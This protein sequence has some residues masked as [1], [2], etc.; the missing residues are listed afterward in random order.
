M[1]ETKNLFFWQKERDNRLGTKT[2]KKNRFS[3]EN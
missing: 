3:G 1:D 2:F